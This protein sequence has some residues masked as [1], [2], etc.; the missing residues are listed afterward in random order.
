MKALKEC[1]CDVRPLQELAHEATVNF[2][3][4]E[5]ISAM[6][7]HIGDAILSTGK[8]VLSDKAA[9]LFGTLVGQRCEGPSDGAPTVAEA[10][11]ELAAFDRHHAGFRLVEEHEVLFQ[12]AYENLETRV[13]AEFESYIHGAL[14]LPLRTCV[15]ISCLV[16]E[17]LMQNVQITQKAHVLKE[18]LHREKSLGD[19][20]EEKA[21]AD[22]NISNNTFTILTQM[23]Q[24]QEGLLALFPSSSH[25][26]TMS[27]F[28]STRTQS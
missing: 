3:L 4:D 17:S 28:T 16:Q 25:S 6:M 15:S 19:S 21:V 2:S 8:T 27:C 26:K 5:T 10:P 12:K 14:P 18:L 20:T 1:N 9:A 13:A 22:C 23:R 11:E 24:L 7:M